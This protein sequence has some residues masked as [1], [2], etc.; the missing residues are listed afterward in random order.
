[1]IRWKQRDIHEKREARKLHI[2]KLNSELS[3][4]A[5]LR[6]RIQTIVT[7]VS[8][9]GVDYYRSV[10]RRLKEN[11]SDEKPATGAA[12]QPTYDMM[13]GQLL[14]D[15]W[16]EAAWLVD[17]ATVEKGVVV[18]G[19]KKVDDKTGEPDWATGAVPDSKKEVLALALGERLKWHVA[20]LDRRDK[21]VK[22]EIE[23]EEAEQK[24]R[25]TSDDIHEGWDQSAVVAPKPSPL[26]DRPKPKPKAVTQTIEVLN[27]KASVSVVW[28]R[29]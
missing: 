5:V 15:V 22:Q 20:E 25:I 16:R 2:A 6:P 1:M 3:L 10:Q 14:G 27:P 24:K 4:N 11:P 28:S 19:G 26:E 7:G 17:G 18:K 8:E 23:S 12:N 9:K 21:E 13:M 29:S